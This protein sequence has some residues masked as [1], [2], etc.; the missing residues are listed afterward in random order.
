L[1]ELLEEQLHQEKPHLSPLQIQSGRDSRASAHGPK[2][3]GKSCPVYEYV[4][5][6]IAAELH[7]QPDNSPQ[8]QTEG[9]RSF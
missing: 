6:E 7:F 8:V 9:K 2:K 3:R 5:V 1:L 4:E